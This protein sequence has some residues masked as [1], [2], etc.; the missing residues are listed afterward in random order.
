MKRFSWYPGKVSNTNQNFIVVRLLMKPLN[1]KL[2]KFQLIQVVSDTVTQAAKF[3]SFHYCKWSPMKPHRQKISQ[4][5]I[6]TEGCLKPN[7]QK[8]SKISSSYLMIKT[9]TWEKLV[10]WSKLHHQQNLSDDQNFIMIKTYQI[11][12]T[13][14]WL[15]LIKLSKLIRRSKLHHD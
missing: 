8:T 13:S 5:F 6:V 1:T 3:M 4:V 7:R 12:K 15:K 11:I 10:T 9:S 14:S 2:H